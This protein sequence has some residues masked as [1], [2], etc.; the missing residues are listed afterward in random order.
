MSCATLAPSPALNFAAD[1]GRL[2]AALSTLLTRLEAAPAAQPAIQL[3]LINTASLI[4][5]RLITMQRA[6]TRL[7]ATPPLAAAATHP[8]AKAPPAISAA[9]ASHHAPEP[10]AEAAVPVPE[11]APHAGHYI[12]PRLSFFYEPSPR[13]TSPRW[14]NPAL[15]AHLNI[16]KYL[17]AHDYSQNFNRRNPATPIPFSLSPA[18][19]R[20]LQSAPPPPGVRPRTRPPA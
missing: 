7:D 10:P 19:L 14:R 20:E 16:A 3:R 1:A 11:P 6:L 8:S 5:Q 17:R 13:A 12:I 2:H 15:H 9:S 18:F 4:L